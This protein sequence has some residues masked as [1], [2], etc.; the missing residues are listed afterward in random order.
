VQIA[1]EDLSKGKKKAR[2]FVNIFVL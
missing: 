1:V 2:V